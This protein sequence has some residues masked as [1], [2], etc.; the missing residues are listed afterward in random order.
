MWKD[1]EELVLGTYNISVAAIKRHP[2][3][4][5]RDLGRLMKVCHAVSLQEAGEGENVIRKAAK[6][7]GF[8]VYFGEGAKGQSSTPVIYRSDLEVVKKGATVVTPPTYVGPAGAGPSVVKQ[9]SVVWVRFKFNGRTCTVGSG[10]GPASAY[11]PRRR[12]L[13]KKF[14]L[15]SAK[16]C[17]D[18]PGLVFW[19]ADQNRKG[20]NSDLNPFQNRGF[21][22]A[23]LRRGPIKTHWSFIDDFRFRVAKKRLRLVRVFILNKYSS[24]HKPFIAVFAVRAKK[25]A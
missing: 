11:L 10:H 3:K 4:V 25:V 13:V 9:K 18:M 23:Q 7:H 17:D 8:K 21:A 19:G 22:S 6:E 2:D 16:V 1:E 20:D 15:N 5:R 12:A 14:F 24:D